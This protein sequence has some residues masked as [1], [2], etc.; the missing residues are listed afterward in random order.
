MINVTS[1]S[2]AFFQDVYPSVALG[3]HVAGSPEFEGILRA[4]SSYADSY[5]ENA[6]GQSG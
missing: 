5:M 3:S 2:Q 4:V 1:T 6:V